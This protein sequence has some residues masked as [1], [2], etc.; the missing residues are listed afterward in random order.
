M[1]GIPYDLELTS[2]ERRPCR[3][4]AESSGGK[5]IR[6]GLLAITPSWGTR[7]TSSSVLEKVELSINLEC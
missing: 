5:R 7:K 6:L 1:G 4:D 3:G 2:G